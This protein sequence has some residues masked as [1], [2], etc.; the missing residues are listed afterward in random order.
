MAPFPFVPV[1]KLPE[2]TGVAGRS[3][4]LVFGLCKL[5]FLRARCC[6]TQF[7]SEEMRILNVRTA[8]PKLQI[9]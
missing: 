6:L 2:A 8:N 7:A 9:H 5:L 1:S 3:S 4:P